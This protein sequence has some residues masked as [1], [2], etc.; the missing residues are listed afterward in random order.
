MLHREELHNPIQ[1]WIGLAELIVRKN[2]NGPL[3]DL[4]LALDG[5]TMRFSHYNGPNPRNKSNS[6]PVKHGGAYTRGID[7]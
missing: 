5:P 3:G 1:G 2:R 7:D 4:L 6:K